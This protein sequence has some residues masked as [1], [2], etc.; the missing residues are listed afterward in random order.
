MYAKIYF[1]LPLFFCSYRGY[2]LPFPLTRDNVIAQFYACEENSCSFVEPKI[3]HFIISVSNICNTT[4]WLLLAEQIASLFCPN[5]Q[6]VYALDL[7]T[8][9][10]HLHFAVNNYHYHPNGQPLSDE[11]F[12]VYLKQICYILSATFPSHSVEII[13]G[14]VNDNV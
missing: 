14:E 5:Y 3:R 10:Y 2:L 6:I 7:E 8:G 1:L 9:H 4:K 12:Q 11:L 13:R